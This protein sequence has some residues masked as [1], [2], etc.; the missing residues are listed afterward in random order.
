MYSW[1]NFGDIA[2]A[3]RMDYEQL[4]P[5]SFDALPQIVYGFHG[6][7]EDNKENMDVENMLWTGVASFGYGIACGNLHTAFVYQDLFC[8]NKNRCL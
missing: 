8:I 1:Q 3:T 6:I 7:D 2:D 5:G 4:M